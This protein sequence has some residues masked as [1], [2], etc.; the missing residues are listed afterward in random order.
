MVTLG[1]LV[2]AVLTVGVLRSASSTCGGLCVMTHG[3]CLMPEWP[4]DSWD[5]RALVSIAV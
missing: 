1:W 4:A 3:H 5:T 2:G